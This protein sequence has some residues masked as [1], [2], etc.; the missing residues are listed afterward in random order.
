LVS[1]N[2]ILRV[3]VADV[4]LGVL[5]APVLTPAV[6]NTSV[7]LFLLAKVSFLRPELHGL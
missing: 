6:F 1:A 2:S 3:L 5:A 7:D 4:P